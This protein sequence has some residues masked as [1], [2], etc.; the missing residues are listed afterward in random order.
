MVATRTGAETIKVRTVTIWLIFLLASALVLCGSGEL[1]PNVSKDILVNFHAQ[2]SA[3]LY[4]AV[5]EGE[6]TF[7]VDMNAYPTGMGLML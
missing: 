7:L 1:D 2:L 4:S 5:S 6:L 3:F